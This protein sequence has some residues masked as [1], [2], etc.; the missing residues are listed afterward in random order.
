[1]S[2]Q[3][4]NASQL[5]SSLDRGPVPK[6]IGPRIFFAPQGQSPF[7]RNESERKSSYMAKMGTD[8][9]A[10]ARLPVRMGFR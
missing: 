4:R 6:G 2:L 5:S 3:A 1:L 8:P 9:L 10:L 7:S